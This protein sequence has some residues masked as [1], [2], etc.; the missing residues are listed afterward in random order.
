METK[1]YIWIGIL[2]GGLIG[3]SIGGVLDHGNM[4]GLWSILLSGVGSIAGIFIAYK[5][6]NY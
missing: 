1:T 5:L 2:V 6:S 3:G 4:L